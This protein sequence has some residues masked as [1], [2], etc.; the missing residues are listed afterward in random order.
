MPTTAKKKQALDAKRL[1]GYFAVMPADLVLVTD[2]SNEF[3]DLRV[4]D[5]IEEGAVLDVANEGI[6]E[7]ILVIRQKDG[8]VVVDGHQRVKRALAANALIGHP[9]KGPVKAVHEC[10]EKLKKSDVGK[11][12][13]ELLADGPV[14]VPVKI[15]AD[16]VKQAWARKWSTNFWRHDDPVIR[17]ATI[18]QRMHAHGTPIPE[19][20]ARMNTSVM[21]VR[22]Y[23]KMDLTKPR[24]KPKK[25]GGDT[26]PR[27]KEIQ[28]A[29]VALEEKFTSRERVLVGWILGTQKKEVIAKAFGVEL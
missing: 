29:S 20:A 19:I 3:Y 28:N 5:P 22:R 23:I 11:R 21:S 2:S 4:E 12:I 8:I 16:D 26:R 10:I 1:G 9:Y 24:M 13:I 15:G 27:V 17:H 25:R 14:Q 18:A 7:N 6:L